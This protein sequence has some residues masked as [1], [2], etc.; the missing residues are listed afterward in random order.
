MGHEYSLKSLKVA[1]VN[2]K[3]TGNHK[4]D[5]VTKAQK[6]NERLDV[7]QRYFHHL[8]CDLPEMHCI[9]SGSH[10]YDSRKKNTIFH[11]IFVGYNHCLG[12]QWAD[13][14]IL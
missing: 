12:L 5:F 3:C 13:K 9:K 2:V 14:K 7:E 6:W 8:T 4:T 11:F 1:F 10:M